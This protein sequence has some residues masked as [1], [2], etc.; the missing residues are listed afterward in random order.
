MLEPRRPWWRERLDQPMRGRLVALLGVVAVLQLVAR[1][2]DLS[3]GVRVGL[4]GVQVVLLVGAWIVLAGALR[5]R[6]RG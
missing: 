2:V 6:R 4:L 5:A 1:A 3:H